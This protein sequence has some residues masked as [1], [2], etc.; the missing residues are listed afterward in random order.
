[1]A[2]P[3]YMEMQLNQLKLHADMPL[4]NGANGQVIRASVIDATL[5]SQISQKFGVD[6]SQL[7]VAVKFYGQ[8]L[9]QLSDTDATQNP[10][11]DEA[12]STFRQEVSIM[13]S[14]LNCQNVAQ[15]FG[16]IEGDVNAIVM[17]MYAGSLAGLLNETSVKVLPI[18]DMAHQVA[19]GLCQMHTSGI[20]HCDIKRHNILYNIIA[21]GTIRTFIT[22]FGVSQVALAK[23]KATGRLNVKKLALSLAYAAPEVLQSMF[24]TE[25]LR[26]E[27]KIEIEVDLNRVAHSSSLVKEVEHSRDIYALGILMW[28]LLYRQNAWHEMRVAEVV[29]AVCVK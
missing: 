23:E 21:D 27:A 7:V 26:Q 14:L 20:T 29:Q 2:V 22:D 28:E 8:G 25:S 1:M 9:K 15:M 10:L 3:G 12:D 13:S 6:S 18:V 24:G 11:A 16:Y 17:R 19:S 5:A 4:G